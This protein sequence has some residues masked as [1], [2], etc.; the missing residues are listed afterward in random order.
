[1]KKSWFL[2]F[3]FFC[4]SLVLGGCRSHPTRNTNYVF[5][6]KDS[7]YW[8]KHTVDTIVKIPSSII[9]MVINPSKMEEGEKK[10]SSKGQAN[11]S[12]EK[13]GDSLVIE[14][15]CDSLELVV[16]SLQERLIKIT[17]QNEQLQEQVKAAPSK[18]KW[19]CVGM[20][21]ALWIFVVVYIGILLLKRKT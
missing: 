4:V 18:T 13:K 1:M 12:I 17:D 5:S 14:A 11:I 16:Y 15:S 9:N 2:C 10:E 7:L 21:S 20:L 6:L 8:E 19:F 3:C